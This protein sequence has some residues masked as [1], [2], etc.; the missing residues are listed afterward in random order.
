MSCVELNIDEQKNVF[1]ITGDTSLIVNNH[2]AKYY[3]T[4]YLK[5]KID[6]SGVIYISY[7]DKEREI[8]LNEIQNSLRKYKIIQTD[9]SEIK[10]VLNHYYSEKKNFK[11]FSEKA[12]RIWSN[13]VDIAEFSAFKSALERHLVNRKLYDK[14]L[15]AAYHLAFSQNACNFSVPGAGKTSIVYGAYAY[16]NSLPED[17]SKYVN[18]LLII[19]PLSS[20]GPW[21][22]E[23]E[24]C[25]GRPVKSKRLSGGVSKDER[26]RHLL[27]VEDIKDTPEITLMSYQSVVYNLENLRHFLQRKDNRVMIVLDEAHKIKN[28][29]GGIWAD[30]VLELAKLTGIRSRVV[31]TGTP[32]PN[33]FEDIYNLYEFI[34]PNKGIINYTTFQLKDMSSNPFDA[35]IDKLI[36]AI[37][38]FFIRIR[39]SDLGLPPAIDNPPIKIK[40]GECQRQIY[41][42]LENNYLSYF[43]ENDITS[44]VTSQLVKAR[45]IRLIQAATNPGLLRKP[46]EA[47]FTD[48]GFHNELFIDDSHIINR[49]LNYSDE[50]LVPK[51]FEAV[52][53]L[54]TKLLENNEKV[55]IWGTFIQNI[56][57]LQE[58]LMH[59]G[60][61][62]QL[63]YGAIPTE[64]EDM[65]EDVITREKII[66]EFHRPDSSFKVI[67]ANPFA[68]AESISL[69]KACHNAIYLERTFNAANFIQSKDRIHRVGLDVGVRT[70]YYYILAENS[71][72]ETIHLR[73]IEK[74]RR[75]LELIES[76][77]IPLIQENMNYDIDLQDDLKA[78]IR[79]YVRRTL[80]A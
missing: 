13:E 28:V 44:E 2:R 45:F 47:Y 34:W 30:S 19:G 9:S 5:A 17:N 11:I 32:I 36:D 48:Q 7:A 58:Y 49:I 46:L 71:I 62:S 14:Q 31:L 33:G 72:D 10:D 37:S 76:R 80:K 1:L 51:K 74:E 39:K 68:V 12:K 54:V 6:D 73:L 25:F 42:A 43:Q 67:I 23:Y 26:T 66:K 41:E 75:M 57:E 60:I 3:F 21:E 20:F 55:I 50:E 8:V 22:N 78:L 63:L 35:R 70:N 77:D 56:K 61:E 18:K 29:D 4:D 24:E 52:K 38:P 64:I 40:M 27:S 79:D 16:L 15:L 59:N 65:P 53:N 69:H